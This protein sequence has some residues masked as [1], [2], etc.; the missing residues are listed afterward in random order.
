MIS[1]TQPL[2]H[3]INC[4]RNERNV[5]RHT[6]ERRSPCC[7]EL[8]RRAFSG[9]QEAWAEIDITFTPLLVTWVRSVLAGKGNL[10]LLDEETQAEVVQSAKMTLSRVGYDRPGLTAS[11]DLSILLKFWCTCTKREVLMALRKLPRH[12]E[13][14]LDGEI[15]APS[16]AYD[17]ELRNA[18][19][20]RL[21]S[22]LDTEE[23]KLIFEL[24]FV[25]S[26]KP[27][28]IQA[29]YPDR[30]PERQ[31]LYKQIAS[32]R[33]RLRNDP[34]LRRLAGLDPDDQDNGSDDDQEGDDFHSSTTRD[35][36]PRGPT[37]LKIQMGEGERGDE[38]MQE[39]CD[40]EESILV[41]YIA[42]LA[43]AEQRAAVEAQP[44]C[45]ALARRLAAEAAR[46]EALLYRLT[47]PEPDQLVA[48][49]EHELQGNDLLTL[50]LHLDRCE[51]CQEDLALLAA[52][53]A[54]PLERSGPLA[55][56]RQLFEA[57]L[58]P[59]LTLQMKGQTHIYAAP[60]IQISL[61]LGR[62]SRDL[63]RWTMTGELSDADGGLFEELVDEVQLKHDESI[64]STTTVDEERIFVFRDLEPGQYDLV[65]VTANAD[66]VVK[67][68]TIG[69]ESV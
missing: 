3:V 13:D 45:L 49:Q 39:R 34:I 16:S 59:A 30:F 2:D 9:N 52:M 51:R 64:Q 17:P 18:L 42:G 41:G 53:D 56:M 23:E 43:T 47:C 38:H 35:K 24:A 60:I 21:P 67:G 6:G 25:Q 12:W 27:A 4:C 26:L 57:I 22:L 63:P 1:P 7:I 40:L 15:V 46:I 28:D 31:A 50:R 58:Q 32:L 14:P 66:V 65:V 20:Q 10:R 36:N 44:G 54:V 5:F 8:F 61:T 37:S 48:Y 33:E 62:S 29:R 19:Q 11:D 68:L 69:G 55:G